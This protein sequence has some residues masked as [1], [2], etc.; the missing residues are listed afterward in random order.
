MDPI[1]AALSASAAGMRAQAL[2]LRV[3]SENLA[4]QDNAAVDPNQD[5]YR[6]KTIHFKNVLDRKLGV[7]LVEVDKILQDPSPFKLQYQPNHPGAD[8]NGYVK[9]SNVRG[10]IEVADMRQ[11]NRSYQAQLNVFRLTKQMQARTNELLR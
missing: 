11:A 4:N 10:L 1:E 6:R 8:E 2:R 3:I 5:P 7:E 9:Y